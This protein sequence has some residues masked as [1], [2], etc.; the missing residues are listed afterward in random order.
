MDQKSYEVEQTAGILPLAHES[1]TPTKKAHPYEISDLDATLVSPTPEKTEETLNF[2]CKKEPA[3][4]PQKYRRLLEL[5]DRMTTSLRLLNLRKQ[6]P[7]FQKIR[8]MVEILT[9]RKFSYKHLAQIKFI[10]P[11]AVQTDKV[12][13]HNK[14][15]LCMEP[16]IKVTLRFDVVDGHTEQ[17]NYIAL[18]RLMS[19]RLI[20]FVNAHSEVYDVPEAELPEPFNKKETTVSEK[21]EIANSLPMKSSIQTLPNLDRNEALIPSHFPSSFRRHF[22]TKEIGN[23]AKTQLSQSPISKEV[24]SSKVL[25]VANGNIPMNKLVFNEEVD[26]PGL[27]TPMATEDNKLKN[28]VNQNVTASGSIVKRSLD[29]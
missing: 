21:E 28:M 27:S 23:L 3:Q 18:S 6:L 20:K 10:I 15:T 19:S 1:F 4:L 9:G 17:S 7:T 24:G 8:R 25:Q 12:L 11:E 16:D 2:R 5:F 13:V 29:F 26:T 14:K 22:S